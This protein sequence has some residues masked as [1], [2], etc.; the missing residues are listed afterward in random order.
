MKY[1]HG[2]DGGVLG[3]QG[4]VRNVIRKTINGASENVD[5]D[6]LDTKIDK[7]PLPGAI[8]NFVKYCQK[9]YFYPF[10]ILNY[11]NIAMTIADVSISY[12]DK[13]SV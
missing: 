13:I 9:V 6:E 8:K 2:L 4:L 7:L 5:K 1:L 10:K 3:L 12:P 11:R